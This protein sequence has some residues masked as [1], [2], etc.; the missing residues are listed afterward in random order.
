VGQLVAEVMERN[1]MSDRL[2]TGQPRRQQQL[3][4]ALGTVTLAGYSRHQVRVDDSRFSIIAA[5]P[6][7]MGGARLSFRK[8]LHEAFAVR[9]LDDSVRRLIDLVDECDGEPIVFLSHNGPTGLGGDPADPWGCDFRRGGGDHGD[10]DLELAVAHAKSSGRRVLAV[11]AGHMH[12]VLKTGGQRCWTAE[13]EGTLYL[14]A[15]RVPRIYSDAGKTWHHHI[16]LE[17]T[18]S[19]ATFCEHL[20]D[21]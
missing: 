5:R 1:E 13:R 16:A 7:S 19:T 20:I 3:D 14:N 12:H 2:A 15:A 6:H 17:L 18:E 10:P 8:Y 4:R 21:L 9:S 11:V